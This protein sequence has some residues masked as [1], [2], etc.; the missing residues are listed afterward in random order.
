VTEFRCVPTTNTNHTIVIRE[1]IATNIEAPKIKVDNNLYS[2][3]LGF[4]S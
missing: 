3:G 2:E 4:K 1:F